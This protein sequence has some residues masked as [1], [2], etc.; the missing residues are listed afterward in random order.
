M[1]IQNLTVDIIPIIVKYLN[2]PETFNLSLLNKYWFCIIQPLL[3]QDFKCSCDDW[4]NF[5]RMFRKP[6]RL[7]VDYR[8]YMKSIHIHT[9]QLDWQLGKLKLNSIQLLFQGCQ[10]INQLIVETPNFNDDD[11]WIITNQ[12]KQLSSLSVISGYS[13]SNTIT[14]QGIIFI[15][16]NSP[17]LKKFHFQT[18]NRHCIT[19]RALKEISISFGGNLKTFGLQFKTDNNGK[20]IFD[21][22]SPLYSNT[23]ES[24]SDDDQFI[25]ALIL[26]IENHSSLDTLILDWPVDLSLVLQHASLK[27]KKLQSLKIGNDESITELM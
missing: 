17:S 15:C 22:T 26:I 5:K 21:V 12:C 9:D 25:Q 4:D 13:N 20:H 27:L 23:S 2:V 24:F 18:F 16:K 10:S 1:S 11:L 8:Q 14:D 6:K 3:W 7:F 19:E